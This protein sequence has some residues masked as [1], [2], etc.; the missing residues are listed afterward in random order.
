M[1]KTLATK[2]LS[3]L[4]SAL[5]CF[6]FFSILGEIPT[7]EAATPGQYSYKLVA[8]VDDNLTMDFTMN[9]TLYGKNNNGT[10]SETQIDYNAFDEDVSKD[11][12]YTIFEGT[13]DY[14]PTRL[15]IED[16]GVKY[17]AVCSLGFDLVLTVNSTPIYL[18]ATLNSYD[19]GSDSLTKGEV[20]VDS[21]TEAHFYVKTRTVAHEDKWD[22]DYRTADDYYPY[23]STLTLTGGDET[24]FTPAPGDA[25]VETS[26]YSADVRDQYDTVW[27]A[28]AT[29]WSVT[30]IDGCALAMNPASGDTSKLSVPSITADTTKK[31]VTVTASATYGTHTATSSQLITVYP[32]YKVTF[33]PNGGTMA[34]GATMSATMTNLNAITTMNYT[35]PNGNTAT[36]D[37]YQFMGWATDTDAETGTLATVKIGHNSTLYAIWSPNIYYVFFYGNGATSGS[38]TRQAFTYGFEANFNAN[39]FVKGGF[40]VNFK[41]NGGTY[42][43][44]QTADSTFL[45]WAKTANGAVA[46]TDGQTVKNLSIYNGVTYDLYAVWEDEEI[47]L[48]VTAKDGYSF[49]GWYYDEELTEKAGDAGDKITVGETMNIYAKWDCTHPSFNSMVV[50]EATCED[51]GKILYTCSTCGY[52]YYEP[53]A[54]KGHSY[55][56]F[57]YDGSVAK[58]HTKTCAND[59]T[60][61]VTESCTFTSEVTRPATC[62]TTG[63]MTYTCSVCGG[64]YT[65]VIRKLDHTPGETVIENVTASSCTEAGTYDEV[66]YC[67]VCK[68]EI[69]RTTKD[70]EL[71]SHVAEEIPA[72]TATCSTEG[73]TSGSRCKNCGYVIIAPVSLGYLDHTP[74]TVT[75]KPAT[76]TTSG[77]TDGTKCSVCGTVITAQQVIDPLGHTPGDPVQEN[78][79]ASTCIK[80]GGYTEKIYCTECEQLLSNKY[81]GLEL[82][83]HTPTEIPAVA[84][85]CETMGYTAGTKCSVCSKVL[86][87][88][89]ETGYGDHVT[90]VKNASAATCA[91]TGYTGDTVCK[92]CGTTTAYGKVIEKL[93]HT[94]VTAPGTPSTCTTHGYTDSYECIECG[95]VETPHTQLPLADHTAGT[96]VQENA[97]TATCYSEGSYDE[98]TYC[99]VCK[100]ELSRTTVNT[101]YAGHTPGEKKIE[102]VNAATCTKTGSQDEVIYCT[103]CNKVISKNTVTLEK[104][105]H[106][107]GNEVRENVV[108]GNCK[109]DGS[110]DKVVYCADCGT[111]LSRTKVNTGKGGHTAGTETKENVTAATCTT[112][113]AYEAVVRCT[114]CGTELSRTVRTTAKAD[115]NDGNGDGLCDTCGEDMTANCS[116]LCH[117]SGFLGFIWKIVNLF[118]K[119]F[120]INQYC[121]CGAK[122]W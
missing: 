19:C 44:Q 110:Y 96:P 42:C 67:T 40:K 90:T 113:G 66:V 21:G 20:N 85:D 52:Q 94:M 17:Y 33:D 95:Y 57:K 86:E 80:A 116:H 8:N 41:T 4:L 122:H 61:T 98:C 102:N 43:S 115:H 108:N 3:V 9:F 73:F 12:S 89:V 65:T 34:S 47:T 93:P 13:S 77:L 58:T 2:I 117:K 103:V 76:C 121:S 82:A 112:Q 6:G 18:N 49:G 84:G 1:K 51:A 74:V 29:Q 87:A 120:K 16:A 31:D 119:L 106:R 10:G 32:T 100:T 83:E 97:V 45:G 81:V 22:A 39:A 64:T 15:H 118:N 62:A 75:G 105:E 27:G 7:A 36:R 26:A 14:F 71:S 5:M 55:G 70:K 50:T 46:F 99:T 111:E 104:T 35:I 78:Y 54:A 109:K 30:E 79:K 88:P 37:G 101:G 24:V 56:D 63:V 91:K 59:S 68:Q 23:P 114:V 72:V 28:T 60:H 38:M 53:I 92:V 69:S 107:A 11:N 48:P 25:N